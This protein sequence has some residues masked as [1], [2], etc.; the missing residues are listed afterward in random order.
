MSSPMTAKI[1]EIIDSDCDN[2]VSG[3]MLWHTCMVHTVSQLSHKICKMTL[4][5][6]I[7]PV[8]IRCMFIARVLQTYVGALCKFLSLCLKTRFYAIHV[9]IL[10]SFLIST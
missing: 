6:C 8:A 5:K 1:E 10:S 4:T 9:L 3:L 7:E 2:T